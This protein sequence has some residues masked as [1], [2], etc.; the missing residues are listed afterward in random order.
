MADA[1]VEVWSDIEAAGGRASAALTVVTG[2]FSESD[3][4]ADALSLTIPADEVTR[5]PEGAVLRVTERSGRVSEWDVRTVKTSPLSGVATVTADPWWHRLSKLPAASYAGGRTP[6]AWIDSVWIPALATSGIAYIAR[7]TVQPTAVSSVDLTGTPIAFLN[8][9]TETVALP[10]VWTFARTSGT[11]YTLH[12]YTSRPSVT[13]RPRLGEDV[14]AVEDETDRLDL[15]TALT[16]EG[17]DGVGIGDAVWSI[18]GS[19]TSRTAKD[20]I[21]LDS[22]F[23]VD[24]EAIGWYLRCSDNTVVGPVTDSTAAGVLTFGSSPT[25]PVASVVRFTTDAAG[26]VPVTRLTRPAAITT[27]RMRAAALASRAIAGTRQLLGDPAMVSTAVPPVG[28]IDTTTNAW[29]PTALIAGDVVRI[30]ATEF[31]VTRTGSANGARG[32]GTGTGTPFTTDGWLANQPFYRGDPVVVASQTLYVA[33]T[34]TADGSGVASLTLTSVNGGAIADNDAITLT[35]PAMIPAGYANVYGY[36]L[37]YA[38]GSSVFNPL[39]PFLRSN[40]TVLDPSAPGPT[41]AR[42][43]VDVALSNGTF[44]AGSDAPVVGFRYELPSGGGTLTASGVAPTTTAGAGAVIVAR[45][46][47]ETSALTDPNFLDIGVH[48]GSSSDFSKWCVVIAASAGFAD[49]DLPAIPQKGGN[50]LWRWGQRALT[51]SSSPARKIALTRRVTGSTA[52]AT[53]PMVGDRLEVDGTTI[54]ATIRS[55]TVV[56]TNADLTSYAVDTDPQR[57][58]QRLARGA[59]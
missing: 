43:W 10:C 24:D 58:S 14:L 30:P 37:M 20:P 4:H 12:L 25:I 34:T 35:R 59:I 8:T 50:D 57:L 55:R 27:Y 22:P 33:V 48:G 21:T 46:S 26:R 31:G 39:L 38:A 29:D 9:L 53:D 49:A 41:A 56:L 7:G 40:A 42:A 13:H 11:T 52:W 18:T 51:A 6:T 16:P 19:G 17:S 32:A 2:Q 1:R 23:V 28:V 15:L 36:R 45:A 5:V 3:D 44:T 54:A 47:V